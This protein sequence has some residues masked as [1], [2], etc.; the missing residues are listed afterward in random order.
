MSFR[1]ADGTE[2]YNS[3]SIF[4]MKDC[5]NT[6]GWDTH[7]M[8]L[9]FFGKNVNGNPVSHIYWG[10]YMY[11]S[12]PHASYLWDATIA[13]AGIGKVNYNAIKGLDATTDQCIIILEGSPEFSV[14]KWNLAGA[15]PSFT[16]VYV[17]GNGDEN[18]K[19][20]NP[21]DVTVDTDNYIYVLD[22]LSN[23]QPK[24]KVFDANL[25]P[26]GGVGNS[27]SIPGTPI[28][29]DWDDF[30]N[31]AHVLHSNGFAVFIK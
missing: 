2:I 16:G 18:S 19:F 22:I 25:Q 1:Q 5:F 20:N 21:V 17:S 26:L 30:G 7:E 13:G 24:I 28:A 15:L 27:T 12:I 14:E 4:Y 6:D 11:V 8:P 31:A 23:G 29:I 9:G 3:G 10:E